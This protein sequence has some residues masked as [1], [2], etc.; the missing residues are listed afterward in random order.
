VN[1]EQTAPDVD[2]SATGVAEVGPTTVSTEGETEVGTTEETNTNVATTTGT[3]TTT[4]TVATNTQVQTMTAGSVDTSTIVSTSTAVIELKPVKAK[5]QN[6]LQLTADLRSL[7][8]V[9]AS[10]HKDLLRESLLKY[11]STV[12]NNQIHDFEFVD[13]RKGNMTGTTIVLALDPSAEYIMDKAG[14]LGSDSAS[15][16]TTT[17]TTTTKTTTAKKGLDGT[18]ADQWLTSFNTMLLDRNSTWY[19][20]SL[21]DLPADAYIKASS[22]SA[23]ASSASTTTTTTTTTTAATDMKADSAMSKDL[24][25]SDATALIVQECP[26]LKS[27]TGHIYVTPT[28][29]TSTG[30]TEFS[31]TPGEISASG[32]VEVSVNTE[33][34]TEV[35][36]ETG[37]AITEVE[38]VTTNE[39]ASS[40]ASAEVTTTETATSTA[41]S[42]LQGTTEVVG[43]GAVVELTGLGAPAP[44]EGSA[45]GDV[46]IVEESTTTVTTS[47]A[48]AVLVDG[49]TAAKLP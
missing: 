49:A 8:Y 15:A 47:T 33:T 13:L 6:R 27:T 36:T 21:L 45:S 26:D 31:A 19:H 39:V 41:M 42:D 14:D 17:T 9:W 37:V 24:L 18:W 30:S 11:F 7:N 25:W 43:T 23:A 1:T 5:C 40:E 2:A 3:T 16:S 20:T 28:V 29:T 35:N 32:T 22:D 4:T 12:S 10:E 34:N 38:E 46:A 44:E 48:A